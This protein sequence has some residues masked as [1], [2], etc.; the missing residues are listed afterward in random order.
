MKKLP[1][2]DCLKIYCTGRFNGAG[3]GSHYLDIILQPMY[4]CLQRV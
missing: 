4:A 1:L 2:Q 3:S